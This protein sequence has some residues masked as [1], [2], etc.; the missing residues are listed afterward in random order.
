LCTR[1][2]EIQKEIAKEKESVGVE[3]EGRG[4]TAAAMDALNQARYRGL[5]LQ[6]L[7]DEAVHQGLLL[8]GVTEVRPGPLLRQYLEAGRGCPHL[9]AD[10]LEA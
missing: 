2:R 9:L 4:R 3:R 7:R 5:H 8:G 6:H 1:G 10:P